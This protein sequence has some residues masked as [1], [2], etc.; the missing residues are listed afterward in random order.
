MLST[1]RPLTLA[2]GAALFAFAP[3]TVSASDIFVSDG[4]NS[5]IF[6]YAPNGSR[7]LFASGIFISEIA[8]GNGL[9]YGISNPARFGKPDTGNAVYSFTSGGSPNLL[10]SGLQDPRNIAV[11]PDGNIYVSDAQT[12][13]VYRY[14]PG[15]TQ[16]VFINGSQTQISNPRAMA[17]DSAGNFFLSAASTSGVPASDQLYKY[18]SQGTRTTL[19]SDLDTPLG[20]AVDSSGAVYE[21]DFGSQQIYRFAPNGSRT[22]FSSGLSVPRLAIDTNDTLYGEDFG[23]GNSHIYRYGP[24][25]SAATF[26]LTGFNVFGIT[27]AAATDTP[28]PGALGLLGGI[29]VTGSVFAA[30]RKRRPR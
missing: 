10:A 27:A 24:N 2:F 13:A 7:T 23:G 17:L 12:S 5:R 21:A 25:G 14:T 11:G 9:L 29:A 28:E 16:S 1:P 15:G 20:L 4:N 8:Y 19:A 18:N 3:L 22:L 26:A 30:R 6:K